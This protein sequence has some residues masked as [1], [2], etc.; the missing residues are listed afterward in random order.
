MDFN[1]GRHKIQESPVYHVEERFSRARE[2]FRFKAVT[3]HI[4]QNALRILN[5]ISAEEMQGENPP[6]SRPEKYSLLHRYLDYLK[7]FS[8]GKV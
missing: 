2:F 7:R 6:A 4:I 5:E 3:K 8:E 1:Q